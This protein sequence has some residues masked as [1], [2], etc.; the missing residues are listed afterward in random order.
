MQHHFSD[1]IISQYFCYF[2]ELHDGISKSD[3]M[4]LW[5]I[6]GHFFHILM[7]LIIV[8]AYKKNVAMAL[9]S[10]KGSRDQKRI[11]PQQLRIFQKKSFLL[12][13]NIFIH[14]T[15]H[16]QYTFIELKITAQLSAPLQSIKPAYSDD[17]KSHRTWRKA[18][19]STKC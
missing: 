16:I 18:T 10:S 7:R 1:K 11:K 6:I 8:F 9:K 5:F 14:I 4:S 2:M 19:Q 12:L 3:A 17:W 13:N 15:Q